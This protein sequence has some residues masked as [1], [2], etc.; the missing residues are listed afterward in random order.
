MHSEAFRFAL[1]STDL[2]GHNIIMAYVGA[3]IY[4]IMLK[5]IN[6]FGS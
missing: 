3:E 5:F 1:K 2:I 4:N 6:S